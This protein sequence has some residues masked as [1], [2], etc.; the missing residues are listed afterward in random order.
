[1][2]SRKLEALGT[3]AG[4]VAHEFNNV[5]AAVLGHA[6]WLR[7]RSGVPGDA[8]EAAAS[9]VEATQ[10]GRD[11]VH[12][13]LA[14]ARPQTGERTPI[15]AEQW[16]RSALR[17][18]EPILPNEVRVTYAFDA[19]STTIRANET[20][21]TQVLLNLAS[22]AVY[23]MR[24]TERRE[25]H[26]RAARERLGPR[27]G[28]SGSDWFVLEITDTGTGMDEIA[29]SRVFDPFFTTKPIGDGT[30]L[31][32]PVVHGLVT[33][34]GGTITFESA[35]DKGTTVRVSLPVC[36]ES[37]T[38][39]SGP[40]AAPVA[41]CN[42][43]VLLVDDDVMVL[44]A[45]T[46]TL[47]HAGLRVTGFTDPYAA[48]HAIRD[49]AEALPWTVAIF[50]YAMPG[51]RGDE[52]ATQFALVAPRVP[53]VLCSGNASDITGLPTQVREVVEKP[54]SGVT[55]LEVLERAGLPVH[56]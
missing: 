23:A 17:L 41:K 39:S 49:A 37:S 34:H 36:D 44:R 26:I 18:V 5:L 33:A 21:L 48:L 20:H 30:G 42:A 29:L 8:R 3:V 16:L 27:T 51:L 35:P 2:Q 9:I 54:V 56:R 50:D 24:S 53:I 22:N 38:R 7:D 40:D 47:E 19:P 11:I 1:M 28:G 45:L 12:S 32:M 4:G 6:E 10:R 14:F 15:D 25:L 31:G 46:R 43:H 55:L 52:L 13:L